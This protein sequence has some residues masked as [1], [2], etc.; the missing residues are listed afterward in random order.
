MILYQHLCI[1]SAACC[2]QLTTRGKV[3]ATVVQTSWETTGRQAERAPNIFFCDMWQL[4]KQTGRQADTRTIRWETRWQ[5]S[6]E[7]SSSRSQICHRDLVP[8]EVRT[9]IAESIWGKDFKT[10]RHLI[11][12]RHWWA[13][14]AALLYG[15]QGLQA[16][17][18]DRL[19]V[20]WDGRTYHPD[21]RVSS[22]LKH[23]Y[24]FSSMKTNSSLLFY[25]F[26]KVFFTF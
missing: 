15:V 1:S 12:S 10:S 14:S 13:F 16:G 17:P 2:C 7:T 6:R 20:H 22:L 8:I 25:Y 26:L 18:V 23:L 24:F 3:F 19:S 11:C 21:L 9:L 5:T 4:T